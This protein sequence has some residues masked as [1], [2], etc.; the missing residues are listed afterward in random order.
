MTLFERVKE[1]SKKNGFSLAEVARRANIGEKSI[2]TWKPS[3]TYPTGVSPSREVLERVATVLNVSVE[4]LLGKTDNDSV[5]NEP[6]RIDV[7]DI[8]NS[9]AML[10]SRDHALSD[11]DR[12]AIRSLVETYLKSK[13]G[14]DRLRKFGGYGDDGKK[15]EK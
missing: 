3:K 14:Q 8:V 9:S 11:E 1:I 6:K 2:Y 15:T 10:T 13:E 12:A 5:E 7:E 4:Y